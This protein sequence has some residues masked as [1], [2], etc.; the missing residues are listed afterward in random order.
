MMTGK[1][2]DL[3]HLPLYTESSNTF[4]LSP[5][6]FFYLQHPVCSIAVPPA[7]GG[8]MEIAMSEFLKRT[9]AEIDL[10]R[11][12]DNISVLKNN[13]PADTK[14]MGVV[15]ADGYG[16]GDRVI[17]RE[18][19]EM[20]VDFFAVS[21]LAEAL[22]LRRGGIEGDI[23]V[24]GFTP[25]S[26]A[27]V[28][29]AQSITQ[30]VFSM[31]YAQEL[32][33]ACEK[34]GVS[35]RIHIKLDTGMGRIGIP[36]E[37]EDAADRIAAICRLPHL[38]AEGFFSHLSSADENGPESLTYT[39]LQT[40]RFQRMQALLKDRGI[41]FSCCHLQNSAGIAFLPQLHYDY[42]RAGIVM[43]GVAPSNLPLPFPLKPVMELKTVISMVKEIPT[44]TAVSYGRTFVS[45]RPMRIATVPIGYADGYPRHL[46]NKGEMLLHGKRARILGNICMDQLLLDVSAIE[47]VR[48]GDIVTVVGQDGDDCI[49]FDEL[50]ALTGTISY[51]LMCLIGRR[52]PRVYRKA[53]S[54]IAVVDYIGE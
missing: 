35:V 15:K 43:Y 39:A 10:S 2:D 27:D 8:G 7:K 36:S 1:A 29:A 41:R 18:L 12:D 11:L 50:A 46:S 30:T 23:L 31:E 5:K 4:A 40:Q 28:I 19:S 20:G 22:S 45:D 24:L 21:N 33:A 53:G 51:E 26:Q 3:I 9:W 42:V 44:G 17:A 38:Q 13:L 52:V 6:V 34:A 32:S 48:M 37:Q 14:L 16:H 25:P 47:N 54:T 49:R